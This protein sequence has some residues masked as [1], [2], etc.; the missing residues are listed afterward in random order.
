MW[1]DQAE[2]MQYTTKA[3]VIRTARSYLAFEALRKKYNCNAVL[4]HARSLEGKWGV[5]DR[6]WPGA[7]LI[8]LQKS[9]V[10]AMCQDYL[11]IMIPQ[12]IG[13]FLT[14]RPSMLGNQVLDP[15]NDF[16]ILTHCGGP[17]NVNGNEPFP[18]GQKFMKEYKPNSP[19]RSPY[20]IWSHAET[21]AP[22]GAP[23]SSTG[24]QIFYPIN[25]P[26]TVWKMDIEHKRFG[27]NV[28]T[29]VDGYAVYND[30]D[31][32]I[33]CRTKL[34]VKT[35]IKNLERHYSPAV[36]GRHRAGIF[37]DL[38]KEIKDLAVLYGFKA[39]DEANDLPN[40]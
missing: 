24:L 11:N 3:E 29:S 19:I 9:G 35:D 6:Y 17:I 22:P 34:C 15:D 38:S 27:F 26:V 20:K 10:Q 31:F 30:L 40:Y 4:T 12:L 16:E 8:E 7:S 28:G 5:P 2:D 37:A 1:I 39:V 33:W 23:G 25:V 32:D 36:W 18:R 21:S 14:G 13:F